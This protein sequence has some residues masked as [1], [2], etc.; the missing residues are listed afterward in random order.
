MNTYELTILFPESKEGS[1]SKASIVKMIEGFVKKNKGEINKS[2]EW[3]VK[4]MA[5]M[6]RKQVSAE[7]VHMVLSL[8]PKDQKS[9]DN[10]LRLDEMILRYMFV[11]V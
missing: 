1:E 6:I 10:T 11:R 8:E 2:E 5:Y 9:L 7:Y 3:G 4:R